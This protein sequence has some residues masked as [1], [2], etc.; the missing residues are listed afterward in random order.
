MSIEALY[1]AWDQEL[2]TTIKIVL[3]ALANFADENGEH[4]FP[5]QAR[6][7]R[8]TGLTERGIRKALAELER[9]GLIARARR[10]SAGH[11]TTNTYVLTTK[12]EPYS[13]I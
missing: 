13:G 8:M 7:A 5:S 10:W 1:W 9:L 12:P 3:V 2:R 4:C 11:Q 6:L